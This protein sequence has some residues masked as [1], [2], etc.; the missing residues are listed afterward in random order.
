M[1]AWIVGSRTNFQVETGF[2]EP[3]S[4]RAWFEFNST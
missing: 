3:L 1:E 2:G 4:R